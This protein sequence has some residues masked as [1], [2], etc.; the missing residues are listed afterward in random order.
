MPIYDGAGDGNAAAPVLLKPFALTALFWTLVMIAAAVMVNVWVKDKALRLIL[1]Q[2]RSSFQMIVDTRYW[3]AS[4]GGVYVPVTRDVQPNPFLDVPNRDI[5]TRDGR[6]LTLINPAYMTR[7]LSEIAAA[8]ND[9]RFHITSRNPIRPANRPHAWEARALRTFAHAGDEYYEW[10]REPGMGTSFR[11]MA[12][13]WT[14]QP[15]L[16][17]HA[18]QGYEVGDLRGGISVSIPA[19]AVATATRSAL[20]SLYAVF[21]VL[22]LCGIAGV[23]VSYRKTKEA[24]TARQSVIDRLREAMGEIKTLKGIIPICSY[25]KKIRRDTG[26]WEQ[27]EAYLSEHSDASFSHGICPDCMRKL[28]PEYADSPETAGEGD[29]V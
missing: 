16:R 27:L 10:N 29:E 22:W 14:E 20:G 2:A 23:F 26:A 28:F 6:M 21:A 5:D 3:N 17:C 24:F 7:Q 25:C 12:P 9:I 4:H 8:R 15:C 13:L 19:D 1:Q 18:V 11:Y